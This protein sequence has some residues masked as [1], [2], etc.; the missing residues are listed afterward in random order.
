L[1][2]G[3]GKKREGEE[4]K[5]LLL[6]NF[7]GSDGP[8]GR[9]K[10]EKANAKTWKGRTFVSEIAPGTSVVGRRGKNDEE[11]GAALINLA[12]R[13]R[14]YQEGYKIPPRVPSPFIFQTL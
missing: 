12:D 14:S 2:G 6:L 10:R 4:G 7:N 8:E 3:L 9:K 11:G 1:G 13:E 5:I